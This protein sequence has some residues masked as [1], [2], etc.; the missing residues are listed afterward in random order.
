MESELLRDNMSLSHRIKVLEGQ[1]S[2]C[3][4]KI[5]LMQ[6]T[7]NGLCHF[8]PSLFEKFEAEYARLESAEDELTGTVNT[9]NLGE[10]LS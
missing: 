4:K 7:I 9:N 1:L 2:I 3:N 8:L 6:S 10:G 5:D